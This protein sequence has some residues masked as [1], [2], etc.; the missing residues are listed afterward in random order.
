M[1]IEAEL[2]MR[3]KAKEREKCNYLIAVLQYQRDAFKH[4][5]V[6]SGY[7]TMYYTTVPGC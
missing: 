6:Y 3:G 5:C 1:V 4:G 7:A 2:E